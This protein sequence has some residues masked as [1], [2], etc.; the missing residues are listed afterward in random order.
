MKVLIVSDSHKH[1]ENIEKVLN[2]VKPIDL[3]IHCGDAEGYEDY[4][5]KIA[6]CPLFIVAGNNDFF[7]RLDREMVFNIDKYKVFLTHGHYYYV[8]MGVERLVDEAKQR[9]VDI[10]MYGHTHR[11]MLDIREDIVIINPGSISYP[12]QDG[13][14]PTYMMMEVDKYGDAHYTLNY[15]NF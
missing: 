12:R 1:N 14:I 13:R 7:S 9:G 15:V 3:M 2:K 6:E 10:V 4:I 8:S 5:S 11:P